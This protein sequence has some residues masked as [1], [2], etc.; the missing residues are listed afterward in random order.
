M[1]AAGR[2]SRL[3]VVALALAGCKA[4]KQ[5]PA[6]TM[7]TPATHPFGIL[8]GPHAVGC[9]SCHGAFASFKEFTCTG[10]HGHDQPITDM[11]HVSVPARGPTT[12]ATSV[13]YAWDSAS[14]LSCHSTGAKMLYDHAGITAS[15]ATCHDAAAPF[16]PLPVAGVGLDGRP[17][18]HPPK[19]SN[20]CKSCH[21]TTSWLG[22]GQVPAGIPFD[23]A[24]DLA[25]DALVP[26]YAG[27]SI[28]VLS[29]QTE[30][31]HMGMN[32]QTPELAPST[33]GNCAGCHQN[34]AVGE[35]FPGALHSSLANAV[36]AA[37][38]P[39]QCIDCHLDC[40][41]QGFVGPL[42]TGRAPA[43]GEMKH[44][45]VVW[46][47]AGPT[48][49]SAVPYDCSVCHQ[50][51][52]QALAATWSTDQKGGTP[53][54]FHASLTAANLPQPTS[55]LDCHANSRPDGLLTSGNAS[56]PAGLSFDHTVP[57]ALDECD[58]C[59]TGSSTQ[60]TS[61]SQGRFHLA[62]ASTTKTC[63]PCHAGER[64]TT[65]AGWLSTSYQNSPFDYGTN[66]SGIT[67]GD[68]QDCALCHANPGTGAW[69]GTQNWARGAFT[70]DPAAVSGT[71][72]VACHITQRPAVTVNGFDHSV[73]GTGDCLGC[74]QAT[75]AAGTYVRYNPVPGGDWQGGV[76]YP[77]STL[78]GSLNQ[79]I[80]VTETSLSRSAT[81]LITGTTSIS[82]TLYNMMLH[83]SASVP[84]ALNAGPTGNA[85][86]TKCWHC[87]TNTAGTVTTFSDGKFHNSL[88]NYSATPG[89]TITPFPQ[90]TSRCGDCHSQMRPTAIVMRTASDLLPMDHAAAFVG[91]TG[92]STMD[93]STCHHNPGVSWADGQPAQA[94]LFHA[95][96]GAS[97]PQDCTVCHYPLM[98][99]A[100]KSD[101]TSGTR[102]SMRHRS[103][104]IAFQGCQTCH[105]TALAKA[106]TTPPASTL[107][108]GGVYHA[109]LSTQPRAC[110]D[111]HAVAAPAANASTQ[112]SVTYTLAAGGTSSNGAQWMNH[113]SSSVAG[114]DCAACHGSDAK[115]S[116]SA[117]SKSD[118]F[119]SAVTAPVSCKECHGLTNGGGS[120]AG[121]KNN[122]PVGLTSSSVLTSASAD[123]TT[124][125]PAGTHDQ[126]THA[127]VN[128]S[129]RDCNACHTQAGKSAVAGV[130]GQEWAQ[131]KFHANFTSANPL[132]MN[133]TTGRCSNCHMNVKPT[134]SFTAF[135]HGALTAT[136]GSQDCSSCHS[137]PGTGTAASPNWLGAGASP[138]FIAVG[139]FT[140]SKPPATTTVTQLG[141]NNLPHPTIAA[142]VACTACH[143]SAS[144]GKGAIGY[145]HKSTLINTNCNSCHEAGTNLIGTPWNGVT[146]EAS[147][148]GDSRPYTLASVVAHYQGGT[149]T[150]KYVNHFY[151][152]DCNQC[153][154]VP[155]GN[156]LVTTGTAYQT[157]WSF[158]HTKSK[159]TNPSTCLMCH[160]NGIPN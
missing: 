115:V 132:V 106:A 136:S 107:W 83:D 158:P 111:C 130:Q 101:L 73:N 141:I 125:V 116:G 46:N 30:V 44:D 4:G 77:G 108:Q 139:G 55:C 82:A 128:V 135:D 160:T 59:H 17:F 75:V 24:Q 52:S 48:A 16:D 47:A 2:I 5:P 15:C 119:H 74:H 51:P 104:Q 11:L 89:G 50:S 79:F 80:T 66:S 40:M 144:G 32:H 78:A 99:D 69:G 23:P 27:T 113:G 71:T 25:V 19:G 72:C 102:Y 91:G 117:W 36:P 22:A 118:L 138:Q 67:H 157:A 7:M 84:T 31:L 38:Q 53:A 63:L 76:S 142:G 68:G 14:C 43:S 49:V 105:A 37:A 26:S 39:G 33:V 137:W 54:I 61:W 62:G 20:D 21:T 65:N 60:W 81:N 8:S 126:I 110:L 134:A 100:A 58:S 152:V 109:S 149:L 147:G 124:G 154:V 159:M 3:V 94:P 120:V 95:N 45:A 56:M 127:D 86:N 156:G 145:D 121:T 123:A 9:D 13:A 90:P 87:H 96:I 112:S 155:A 1:T 35:Y 133:G 151:P 10:C 29:P 153:H 98:A 150:V 146:A 103:A 64:P 114:K 92:T 129:P 85:D 42:N 140:V 70:H 148:A 131:A 12:P 97:T 93:C 88:S 28:S 41:P 18:T 6:I 57:A 143:T 122:L 34:S